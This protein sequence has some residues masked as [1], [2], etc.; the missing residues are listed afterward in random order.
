MTR[1]VAE[2]PVDTLPGF[3]NPSHRPYLKEFLNNLAK[4]KSPSIDRF[5]ERSPGY[6]DVGKAV[7]AYHLMRCESETR[8]YDPHIEGD[9]YEY[10]LNEIGLLSNGFD[11]FSKNKLSV[12]TYNYDR[13]FE[14]CLYHALK[15][16]CDHPGEECAAKVRSIP[17]IHLHG[18]LGGL[19]ELDREGRHYSDETD[20]SLLQLAMSGIRIVSEPIEKDPGDFALAH[21]VLKEAETVIFLGFGYLPE[22]VERLHLDENH[23]PRTRLYGTGVGLTQA[24]RE[25]VVRLFPASIPPIE[26]D[27]ECLNVREYL[28]NYRNLLTT[29]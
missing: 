13:S 23:N 8:L 17:I 10:L 3:G 25:S 11:A 26:I 2:T 20:P 4:S 22:N 19:P 7:I 14:Y 6:I 29:R 21:S 1:A 5:L 27:D 28:R 24:E 9:W 12:I 16:G 15:S 18:K